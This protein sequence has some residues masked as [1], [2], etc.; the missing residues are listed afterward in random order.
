M[1]KILKISGLLLLLIIVALVA[2][3]Y[4]YKDE[5][6][7]FIK[8][9]LNKS[10][11]ATVDFDGVSLSL[12]KNFPY[13]NVAIQNFRID[14][15][16]AFDG[17]RLL[18]AEDF[19]MNLNAKKV[20]L[21]KDL[22][23]EEVN[24]DKL[25]LNVLIDSLGN[26]NYDI[27]KKTSGESATGDSTHFELKI[28]KYSLL[29]S[30]IRY[31]DLTSGMLIDFEDINH[32]GK[33]TITENAYR[34]DTH[35]EITSAT[36]EYGTRYLN[37]ARL[38]IDSPVL[39]EDDYSGYTLTNPAVTVNDLRLFFDDM[40]VRL[41]DEGVD[42]NIRFHT[43]K[44]ALG[45]ILSL[46]P[47]AYTSYL[48][49]MKAGGKARLEGSITGMY[50]DNTMP[51][52]DIKCDINHG[53]L[54]HEQLP[55]SIEN[56]DMQASV[57]FPGGNNMDAVSVDIP[58][59]KMQIAGSP[60]EG[61]FKLLHPVSDPYIE[62]AFVSRM[63]LGKLKNTLE[64]PGVR[65]LSGLLDADFSLKGKIS[66]VEKEKYQNVDAQG[67]FVL[68]R[69]VFRSDSLP[70]P[71]D[72][73]QA[74]LKVKPDALEVEK[75]D[76]RTKKS[77]FSLT[78]K[79]LNYLA[80]FLKKDKILDIDLHASSGKLDLNEFMTGTT[81]GEE[82]EQTESAGEVL[83]L[84]ANIDASL[85]LNASEVIYKDLNIK[86]VKGRLKLH[87][88]RAELSA[89]L[90]KTLG[91]N[92]NM[93][94]YYDSAPEEPISSFQIKMEKLSVPES[95]SSLS[96]FETYTPVL[97]KVTGHFF[98]DLQMK[99][100]LDE[101]MNPIMESLDMNG[102]FDSN[103]LNIKGIEM[104][105]KIAG[106]LHIDELT[107]PEIE[108]IRARFKIEKGILN[109]N[110][111]D[112]KYQNMKARFGG[113]VSLD[114]KVNFLFHLDIPREKLGNNANE[115]LEN[116]VGKLDRFGIDKNQL[117]PGIIKMD[118]RITG[119][120]NNPKILPVIAGYEGQSTG[121][122][123]QQVV[124][125]KVEEVVEEKVEEIRADL[126]AKADKIM[127][128]AQKQADALMSQAQK[129][130]QKIKDEAR[131]QGDKLVNKAGNPL[132]KI[133]AQATAKELNRQAGKKASQ[134][135]KKARQ[136][137]DNILQKARQQADKILQTDVQVFDK[138][139]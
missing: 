108:R 56:I 34:L 118:F 83:R 136:Q 125:D 112:F 45:E 103:D 53:T 67:Y 139:K 128:E 86:D 33:G 2:I 78:G 84:P 134:V 74:S 16:G 121:E 60:A 1:K 80:Y 8:D 119:D 110:P 91:G 41:K 37:R 5:I 113:S 75:M 111:F 19:R 50:N 76:I 29:H 57:H 42:M 25:D 46:V 79:A 69:M 132:E 65:E 72:I 77:D 137:A 63:D 124:E 123:I 44:N 93:N 133:A 30:H 21:D 62:T 64:L 7:R 61:H 71:L 99:V 54:K 73:P 4:L 24:I 104:V 126:Q 20:F 39:I 106:M 10:L 17:V 11:N 28:K 114:K 122:I 135:L 131:I 130:A 96:V 102:S 127:A 47:P 6:I 55:E 82:T 116:L 109:I 129:T 89:L 38:V 26:A 59:V 94:G 101:Q 31:H 88:K 81:S 120:M 92:L 14:G 35:T 51:A 9:D 22:S 66:D 115:L 98:S 100:R 107:N 138:D 97:K 95:A 85:S 87:D 70:Y 15:K 3:P 68:D 105:G 40:T 58:A 48:K 36:V 27:V 32:S 49:G 12:I 18:S 43:G 117:L 13:L 23:V 52:F 90:M